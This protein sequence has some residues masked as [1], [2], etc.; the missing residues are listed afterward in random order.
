VY[1]RAGHSPHISEPLRFARE[2]E[3]FLA[4]HA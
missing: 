4:D 1:P 3:R 2:L